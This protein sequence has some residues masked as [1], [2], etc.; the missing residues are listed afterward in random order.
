VINNDAYKLEILKDVSVQSLIIG[1]SGM[2]W[3]RCDRQITE[4]VSQYLTD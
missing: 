4:F 3:D 2:D 1:H